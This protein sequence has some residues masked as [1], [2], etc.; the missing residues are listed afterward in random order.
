MHLLGYTKFAPFALKKLLFV[1]RVSLLSSDSGNCFGNYE[2]NLYKLEMFMGLS[3]SLLYLR[4]DVSMVQLFIN[5][6]F[7]YKML[8]QT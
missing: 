3:W 5:R 1:K 2:S 7:L 6:L 8:K 4:V